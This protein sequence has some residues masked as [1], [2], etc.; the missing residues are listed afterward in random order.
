MISK[1]L[2]R[3]ISLLCAC[4]MTAG[5]IA[6]M[7]PWAVDPD[8]EKT[9]VYYDSTV[10]E[11][12]SGSNVVWAREPEYTQVSGITPTEGN[13][14]GPTVYIDDMY[15]QPGEDI[16]L[17]INVTDNDEGYDSL[18]VWLDIDTRYFVF[19]EENWIPGDSDDPYY[20]DSLQFNNT[21][22]NPGYVKPGTENLQTLIHL[23]FDPVHEHLSGDFVYASI[24]LRI[25][26]DT[27]VGV[28]PMFLD[29]IGHPGSTMCS[30]VEFENGRFEQKGLN[31]L[32]IS[33]N[34]YIGYEPVPPET[35]T[36]TT[37]T[38]ETTT[39]TTTTPETTTETTTTPETTAETTTTPETT[40]E[41]TTTSETTAITT[42]TPE[43]TTETTTTP[44]TAAETTTTPETTTET[45]TTPETT[46]E[47]TTTSETTTETTTTPE[48]TTETTTTSET[49]AITTTTPETTAETTTT[50]ETTAETTTTPETT[51]ETTTTSE[52]TTETTTTSETTTVTTTTAQ[53]SSPG[54]S[55]NVNRPQA[56]ID[57]RYT[58]E[59]KNITEDSIKQI[60]RVP[61]KIS[62]VSL[63][64]INAK[65]DIVSAD[66][67]RA[68]IIGA[69]TTSAGCVY[70]SE[71]FSGRVIWEAVN[72]KN[73]NYR[74]EN[75]VV[76]ELIVELP[77]DRKA[78]DVYNVRILD[79]DS[80]NAN[81]VTVIPLRTKSGTIT[82]EYVPHGDVNN[83]GAVTASDMALMK[84]FVLMLAE[85]ENEERKLADMNADGKIN[86]FDFIRLKRMIMQI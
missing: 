81:R 33:G 18:M 1:G 26:E 73:E 67:K 79:F 83:D 28:Y 44:E 54:S 86:V 39:E 20:E 14:R 6:P 32:Y 17:K 66:G 5:F 62:T 75:E 47:T 60:V 77:A 24:P 65:F 52:T 69:E 38:P 37:T 19:D 72:V 64:A 49:T 43:T 84:K 48:T 57:Y 9:Y 13:G 71:S 68:R 25:K 21:S 78:G 41:T 50:P 35:T 7:K 63:T 58:P 61:V 4:G 30:R 46:T 10:N 74:F 82:L 15:A 85:P 3:G 16:V 8:T 53:T 22:I 23:Y 36:E 56:Y 45:T 51:A 29:Y 34:V 80:V 59:V 2:K 42:T 40:T 27:P 76:F 11:G 55:G 70:S 12:V 31:P